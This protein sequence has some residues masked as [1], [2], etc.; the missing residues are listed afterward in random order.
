MSSLAPVE[1]SAML[2]TTVSQGFM[3]LS[4]DGRTLYESPQYSS[5]LAQLDEQGESSVSQIT[6]HLLNA[7]AR[8]DLSAALTITPTL[9]DSATSVSVRGIIVPGPPTRVIVLLS[10]T[11]S[12]IPSVE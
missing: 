6:S 9:G 8:R 10:S 5:L 1:F 4:G 7:V 2:Q 12:V 11:R 3:V